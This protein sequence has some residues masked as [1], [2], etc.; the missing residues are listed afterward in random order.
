MFARLELIAAG[1]DHQSVLENLVEL[2][3]HDFSEMVPMDV[4]EDGRYGYRDLARFWNLPGHHG[5][6]AKVDGKFAA[7]ALV[8]RTPDPLV[9]ED[10]WDMTEFFVLRRYRRQGVGDEVAQKI[11]SE[12]PG[13]W[14]IRVRS[15][16]HPARSFWR[17]AIGNFTGRPA[18]SE[19]IRVDEVQWHVFSFRSPRPV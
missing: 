3:I 5:F 4:G 14:R 10:A 18:L 8:T 1:P 13:Q 7:F 15:N 17:S 16:N 6:L 19:D 12:C 2:Y 11:W 9:E